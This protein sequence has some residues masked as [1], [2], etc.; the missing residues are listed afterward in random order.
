M[1]GDYIDT[2][3][4]IE[5]GLMIA[6]FIVAILL[7]VIGSFNTKS[8]FSIIS[9][10]IAFVLL[11]PLT[12]QISRLIGALEISRSPDLLSDI[13]GIVSPTLSKYITS[14]TSHDIGWFIFRRVMWSIIFIILATIGIINTME[15]TQNRRNRVSI[16]HEKISRRRDTNHRP[17]RRK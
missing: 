16:R 11:F 9:Y 10:V 7:L 6:I 5:Y 3:A 2:M 1:I 13:V 15:P 4:N 14:V 8:K 12:F 17:Y